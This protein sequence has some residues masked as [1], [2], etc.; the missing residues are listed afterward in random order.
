MV[1]PAG[2]RCRASLAAFGAVAVAQSIVNAQKQCEGAFDLVHDVRC[3][4][5]QPFHWPAKPGY[6]D[7]VAAVGEF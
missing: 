1:N 6:T 4:G 3:Q 5:S 2:R 7:S